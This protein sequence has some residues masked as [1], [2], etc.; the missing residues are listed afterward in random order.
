L[1]TKSNEHLVLDPYPQNAAIFAHGRI[2]NKWYSVPVGWWVNAD[3]RM[4]GANE[5]DHL[6]DNAVILAKR[7]MKVPM[8]SWNGNQNFARVL[9]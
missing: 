3:G 8:K 7:N 1:V 2:Q 9:K 6:L 5:D 4:L